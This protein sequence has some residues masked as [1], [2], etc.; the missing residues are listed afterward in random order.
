MTPFSA[1]DTWIIGNPI[2]SAQESMI[3][4]IVTV[5]GIALSSLAAL[6]KLR[7][8]SSG[9]A[10]LYCLKINVLKRCRDLPHRNSHVHNV[11]VETLSESSVSHDMLQH[12]KH[13]SS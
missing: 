5:A 6:S 12:P 13:T 7:Y 11:V 10:V 8:R 1:L 9:S 2:C 4:L 3:C